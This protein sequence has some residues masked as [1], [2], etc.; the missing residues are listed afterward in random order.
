M[1]LIQEYLLLQKKVETQYGSRTVVLMQIGTFYEIYEYRPEYCAT[2]EAKIDKTGTVWNENIGHA[3]ELSVILNSTLTRENNNEPYSIFNPDKLGFPVIAVEK[4][5]ATLLSNDYV[6]VRYDQVKGQ[7]KG[8]GS[9]ER[10]LAEVASPTMQLNGISLNRA[11]SNIAVIYIEY[12]GGKATGKYENFLITTGVAV[13]DIITGTNRI[14]EFFSKTEDQVYAVQELYRFLISHYPREL[15]IHVVDMPPGLDKHSEDAPNAYVRYLQKTLELKRFDRLAVHVNEVPTEYK[16]PAY[17]IEFLNKLFTK[18]LTQPNIQKRN[19]RIIE[20][21]GLERMNYGR[22]AY[23]LLMQHCHAHNTDIIARLTKPDLQW[24]DENKHLILT[25]NAIIQLN[26]IS[27]QRS[28]QRSNQSAKLHKNKEIDSLMSILDHTMTHLGKRALFNVLQ[29]PLVNPEEIKTYYDMVDEMMVISNL[30]Q[31]SDKQEPLWLVL[32]KQLKELPD[33]ARLQRKLEIK[34]ISPKELSVLYGAYIKIIGIYGSVLQTNSPVLHKQMLAAEDITNFN[35]FM[36]RFGYILD[37]TALECCYIDTAADSDTKWL[38]FTKCPINRGCYPDLDEQSKLLINAETELQA[39]VDH[40]N[41]FLSHTRGKKLELTA[42]KKE[43]GAKKQDPTATVIV[44]S[45]SKAETLLHANYNR[46][47]CGVLQI[48]PY[49]VADRLLTSDKINLL[50]TTIDNLRMSMR[51]KLLAIYQSILDE[52]VE[53]YMFFTNMANFVAKLDLIHSYAK[54]AQLYNYKRPDIVLGSSSVSFFESIGLRHPIIERIIDGAYV[55][56]NVSLGLN[57]FSTKDMSQGKLLYGVN[58]VGKS[59]LVKS[60]P[61]NI[62]MAQMGCFVAATH[63]RYVPYHKIIT[64]LNSDDNIFQGLSTFAKELE[65]LRTILRQAG[66]HT[67]VAGDELC[68]GTE[69]HSGMAIT[70]SAILSLVESKTSFIFATHMHELLDLSPIKS[71]APS[72]LQICHLSISY[73]EDTKNLIYDRK[74][75]EGPGLSTYGLMVAKSLE[76][77]SE[78]IDRASTILYEIMGHSATILSTK[79]SRY[80]SEIYVDKCANCNKQDVQLHTHHIIEQKSADNKQLVTKVI[81]ANGQT[82]DIGSLHKNAK[83]NLIILCHACH[84]KL[85]Q[86]KQQLETVSIGNGTLVRLK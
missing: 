11:T 14:C 22:L 33:I 77:P 10:Y 74:L 34:L 40:L 75:R 49:T 42:A 37:F 51:I 1:G 84:E 61:L 55:T 76:L 30:D 72:T 27:D 59:S 57:D 35:E 58:Q 52:M 47:L 45:N 15:I 26:L 73:D 21:L 2:P 81:V 7:K 67:L 66:C 16:K 36:T 43:V 64:C 39:V 48:L 8:S 29:N 69:S 65:G 60:A 24:L 17:Q 9:T 19:E 38:E 23:L 41:E 18:Q 28:N 78:F 44:T 20:Q 83:D 12:Q 4:N 56:N 68:S 31:R 85:H 53:K 54:V 63:F 25:H 32:N 80:N 62:I 71:L 5:Y 50:S 3:V 70:S 46:H 82:I 13:V 6:I 86:T 79:Q